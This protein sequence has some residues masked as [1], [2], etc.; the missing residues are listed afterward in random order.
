MV[1]DDGHMTCMCMSHAFI[2]HLAWI[3]GIINVYYY[4]FKIAVLLL[5]L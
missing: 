5:K 4:N 3:D 1:Y 2:L